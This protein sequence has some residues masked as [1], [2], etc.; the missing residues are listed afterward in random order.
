MSVTLKTA[1]P[2]NRMLSGFAILFSGLQTLHLI[3]R[4]YPFEI[5][6]QRSV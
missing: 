2:D 6:N 5:I 1:K 3:T 4:Q